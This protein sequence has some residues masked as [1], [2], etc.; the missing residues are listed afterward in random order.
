MALGAY[1]RFAQGR[2]SAAPW[3]RARLKILM[4]Q[5]PNRQSR[6]TL[7]EQTDALGLP[8]ARVDWQLTELDRHTTRAMT[9]IMDSELR[10]LGLARLRGPGWLDDE[11]WT[12]HFEEGCHHMGT[13]RMSTDPRTGVVDADGRVH[14]TTGLYASGSSVF[15][16]GGYAN[17]TLTI[18]ALALRLADHVKVALAETSRVDAVH[19]RHDH[20]PAR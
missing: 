1:R 15:P 8:K 6:V 4:E 11:D 10:R 2:P 14:G 16:T 5:A 12:T 17:P 7:S 19:P 3:D 20:R 9:G 13:T 18:V